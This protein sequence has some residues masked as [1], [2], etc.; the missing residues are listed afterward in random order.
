LSLNGILN[1]ED[2]IIRCLTMPD[3]FQD[4]ASQNDQL[5]EAGLDVE[6]LIKTIRTINPL[7]NLNSKVTIK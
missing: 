2:K 6:G 4:H 1:K 3:N 5:K 7:T